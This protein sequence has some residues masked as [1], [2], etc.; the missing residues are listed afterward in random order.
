MEE[1]GGAGGAAV[2]KEKA[3]CVNFPKPV[4]K[5]PQHLIRTNRISSHLA[6]WDYPR[7]CH[8]VMTNHVP[9]VWVGALRATA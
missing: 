9:S 8:F 5:R 2:Q 4:K 6:E 1:K 7:K 3:G